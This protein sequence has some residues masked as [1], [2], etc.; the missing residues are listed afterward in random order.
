MKERIVQEGY[1]PQQLNA[2]ELKQAVLSI[3]QKLKAE[4]KKDRVK[5][6]RPRSIT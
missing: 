2:Q 3:I 1:L 6:L 4:T 5:N